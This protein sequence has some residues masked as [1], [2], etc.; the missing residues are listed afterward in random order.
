M[1]KT[2]LIVA[3]AL[4]VATT[5]MYLF[6][7]DKRGDEINNNKVSPFIECLADSGV[8][9]FGSSTCPYCLQLLGEYEGYA[10]INE[11]YVDCVYNTE[12]CNNEMLADFVPSLQIN[13]EF[14]DIWASPEALSQKTGCELIK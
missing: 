4:L 8:V 10:G 2:I 11:I 3:V 6:F 13:G 9:I 14:I 5:S 7:D 12:R 1:N